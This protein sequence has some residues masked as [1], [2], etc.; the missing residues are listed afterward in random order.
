MSKKS[1]SFRVEGNCGAYNIQKKDTVI[2]GSPVDKSFAE[3]MQGTP[4]ENQSGTG[5]E[6]LH[7]LSQALRAKAYP[8]CIQTGMCARGA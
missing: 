4:I 2:V 6:C 3:G 5:L 1:Q 7:N 8:D